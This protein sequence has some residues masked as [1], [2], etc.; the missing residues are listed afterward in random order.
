MRA[1]LR[2][3]LRLP[4]TS[5]G[6][7]LKAS[8]QALQAAEHKTPEAVQTPLMRR[9]S[10]RSC[11]LCPTMSDSTP[12]KFGEP[13]PLQE[14]PTLAVLRP[15]LLQQ[16]TVLSTCNSPGSSAEACSGE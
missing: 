1:P 4:A 15:G 12:P 14:L 11:E 6:T 3:A 13:T 10:T 8:L 7:A 2:E 5:P 16:Q 9:N